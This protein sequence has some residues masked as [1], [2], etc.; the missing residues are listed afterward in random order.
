MLKPNETVVV[1]SIGSREKLFYEFK[2][3]VYAKD[4]AVPLLDF[5]NRY[6]TRL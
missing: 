2:L 6:L 4:T 5:A 3:E 1:S